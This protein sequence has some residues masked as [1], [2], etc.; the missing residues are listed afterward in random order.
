[1]KDSNAVEARASSGDA[2]EV[3]SGSL[4]Q[5]LAQVSGLL[6][7]LVVVTVLARRL[8]PA[9]LGTYG[10][11]ATLAVYLLILKTSIGNA[12]VRAMTSAQTKEERVGT[13][14]TCVALYVLTG[15]IT[16]TLI[17]VAGFAI[18]T[19]LLDGEL[20]RQAKLGAAALGVVTAVG[21]ATTINLDA[22]RASLLLTRSAANEIAAVAV[23]GALMLGLIIADA[24]LWLL[25]AGNGSIPLISGTINGIARLRLALPW[26][27][28][29]RS[30]TRRRAAGLVPSAGPVLVIETASLV[31]YGLD[32]I[33]LGIFGS[34]ATVGRYEGP[35]RVHNVFYALN[36]ALGV[37]ALPTA[38]SYRAAGD[39]RRLRQLAVRG[40]RYTLA[41]TVPLAVTAIVLAGP[42]LAVWLGEEY[43]DGGTALAILVS[44]WLLMGQ[45]AVT[46]NFLVGAGR[47]REVARTVVA[48]AVLNLVLSIALTPSLG[49]EGPALG[50][51]ISYLVG[52]PFLLRIALRTTGAGLDELVREAWLPAYGLGLVLAGLLVA[53]RTMFEL[54]SLGPLLA[55]LAGGPL[56]YWLLYATVVLRPGERALARAVLQGRVRAAPVSRGS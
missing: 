21:L 7:L 19:G 46:P 37:T 54:D 40:S 11:V 16:G 13:F 2:R 12:A 45:L 41:L 31:I 33:V 9:E 42:A 14:S 32:R 17:M 4:V 35:I 18:A 36:Q 39:L 24:D 28:E 55:V 38:S 29:R 6:V 56:L 10:L 52:F 25:I 8:T 47:A 53:A 27:F 5:Q 51:A 3:A 23:F 48:I 22:L 49:L 30:V 15:V 1:M 34:A 20:A 44:Y 26:R 50:T 43:R